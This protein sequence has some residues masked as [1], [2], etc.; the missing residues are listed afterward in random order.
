MHTQHH[1]AAYPNKTLHFGWPIGT[2]G[3]T[4]MVSVAGKNEVIV[5]YDCNGRAIFTVRVIIRGLDE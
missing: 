2:T 4:G 5:S 1:N 3:Y